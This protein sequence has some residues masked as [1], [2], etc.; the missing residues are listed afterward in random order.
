MKHTAYSY[1][2]KKIFEHYLAFSDEPRLLSYKDAF[3]ITQNEAFNRYDFIDYDTQ[4][5]AFFYDDAYLFSVDLNG[6][7]DLQREALWEKNLENLKSGTLGDPTDAATLLR[8]WQSQERAH[9]PYARENV[10]Y[11]TEILKKGYESNG[12]KQ[13]QSLISKESAQDL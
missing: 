1:L 7:A 2:D 4:T 6:G 9:Y 13:A 11:F 5:G 10:E 3:G 12:N 8:Y